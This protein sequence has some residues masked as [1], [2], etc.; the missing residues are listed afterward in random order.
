MIN[1]GILAELDPVKEIAAHELFRFS[2]FGYEVVFSNH[3]LMITVSSVFLM[4]LLPFAVRKREFVRRGLGNFIE[5]ICVFIRED[6]ARPFLA[7]NTDKYVGYLWTLF[8]FIVTLNLFG[9]VPF[10]KFFSIF[11]GESVH[12][13]G[14]ATANIWVTGGLAFLSF[15]IIHISGI[16][17]QGFWGYLKNFAPPVPLLIKPFVYL[18]EFVSSFIKPFALA[19]RLF[20]NIFAG[21]VLISVVL[22]FILIFKNIIVAGGS[23]M[24]AVLMSFIEL[25]VACLQAY[26]FTFLTAIFIS[27]SITEDH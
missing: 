12:I 23:I 20:A 11:V 24:F 15:L 9:L 22:S 6:I 26:I 18:I 17:S 7:E 25:F 4:V 14:A 2:I 5:G 16:R 1:I 8:F 27:F 3:M 19:I 13:G 10:E 21:H